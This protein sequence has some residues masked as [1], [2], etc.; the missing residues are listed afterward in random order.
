VWL[1]SEGSLDAKHVAVAGSGYGGF[2]ALAALTNYGDRLVGGV[3]LAG[4]GDFIS[5]LTNT[6]PYRRSL[7]RA[8]YGDERDPDMRAYL[9]RISPLT[10]ADRISKPLLVVHGRN[11]PRVPLSE[12]QQVVARLRSRGAEVWYLEARDEGHDFR[13]KQNRDA[14]YLTF[15]QFIKSLH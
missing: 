6:S 12:S 7:R 10:N 14:F 8:E 2:L 3:D 5:F 13:R 4:M 1:S 15:A 9:R 11:D